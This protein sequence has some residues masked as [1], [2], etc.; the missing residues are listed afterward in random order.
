MDQQVPD[1]VAD[2]L[3]FFYNSFRNRA[4]TEM[5]NWYENAWPALSDKYYHKS[6][7]P[8]VEVVERIIGDCKILS[9]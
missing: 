4:T 1:A 8:E 6:R 3:I 7:W 5:Q 9:G 2:Y